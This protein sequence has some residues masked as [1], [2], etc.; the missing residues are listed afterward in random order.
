VVGNFGDKAQTQLMPWPYFPLLSSYSNHPVSKNLENVLSIFPNSIDTVKAPGIRKTIL[1]SSSAN[2]RTLNTPAMVSF[3]SV[4]TEEDLKTFNK[5][6]V[7]VAVL[8]EGKFSSPF[9]NRISTGI[10]D[11]LSR[12]YQQP[13]LPVAAMDN[14]MIVISDG[15]LVTNVVTQNQGPLYMGM[16]QFTEYQYANKDFI[17]NCIEYL[18]NPSGILETRSK[19]FTLRLLD[20]AKIDSTR[21][22]WQIINIGLP[23]LLVVIFGL[24]Y[25]SVRKRKYSN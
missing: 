23:I 24:L 14:K 9:S 11:T 7:P 22:R 15:D 17:L 13:F 12:I 1:L 3:N 4:K 5:S 10:T 18:V 6:H 20:P 19:D 2:T 21:S 8:L 25:Q 16:N